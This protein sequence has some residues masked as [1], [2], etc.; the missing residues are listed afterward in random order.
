VE[1]AELDGIVDWLNPLPR[2]EQAGFALDTA[3]FG[4]DE[5]KFYRI[6][7]ALGARSI[8]V[9]DPFSGT[10]PLERMLGAFA[11]ICDRA[12]THGLLVHLE[13]LSWGAIPDLATA[14]QIVAGAARDNGGLV[15]DSLHLMRSNSLPALAKIPGEKIFTTQFSDAAATRSGDAFADAASRQLPGEGELNLAAIVRQLDAIGSRAPLGVEVF[16]AELSAL[17]TAVAAQRLSTAMRGV[18]ASAR[19]AGHSSR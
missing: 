17:S 2:P 9:V 10:A 15:I 4:H 6:A 7:D 11:A 19:P 16:N 3:F 12:A 5:Q 13:F 14:W 18:L 1:I 8:T